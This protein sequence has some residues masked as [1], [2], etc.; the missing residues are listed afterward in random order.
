MN[1][2]DAI[3]KALTP[4]DMFNQKGHVW[5]SLQT[6]AQ[7]AGCERNEL[8]DILDEHFQGAVTVRPN[9][10]HPEHGPLIALNAHIPANE[11]DPQVVVMGGNAVG[12]DPDR[13]EA[14]LDV[15]DE[16]TAEGALERL[17]EEPP[18]AVGGAPQPIA[19]VDF[20]PEAEDDEDEGNAPPLNNLYLSADV[21]QLV[22]QRI[23]NP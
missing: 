3:S 1:S 23:C 20:E 6:L 10:G 13:L 17:D 9:R 18:V 14:V 5:R 2:R 4:G 11:G 19:G 7:F 21:A 15:R 22:E 8:L 12:P 16:A